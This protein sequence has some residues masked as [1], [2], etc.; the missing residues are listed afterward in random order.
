MRLYETLWDQSLWD[1]TP[2]NPVDH[3]TIIYENKDY[4]EPWPVRIC[5][6]C[7]LKEMFIV[8]IVASY[9]SC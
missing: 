5:E 8:L 1:K 3:L 4:T 9:Y 2:Q 7:T 6:E